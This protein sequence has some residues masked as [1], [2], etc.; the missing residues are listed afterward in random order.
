MG[1]VSLVLR[2]IRTDS[3]SLTQAHMLMLVSLMLAQ[4][5]SVALRFI[6]IPSF[7]RRFTQSHPDPP[8]LTQICSVSLRFIQIHSALLK[9]IQIHRDSL[10][11]TW[12][13][14][15]NPKRE[16]GNGPVHKGKREGDKPVISFPIRHA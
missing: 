6:Q 13:T 16:K 11:P 10:R 15:I 4:I 3:L 7:P 12:T 1:R 2:L 14:L 9:F 5:H 8:S